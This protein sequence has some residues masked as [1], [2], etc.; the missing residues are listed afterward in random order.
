MLSIAQLSIVNKTK[1]GKNDINKTKN[2]VFHDSKKKKKKLSPVTR[3][4]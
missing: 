2:M 1:T 3:D 4:I